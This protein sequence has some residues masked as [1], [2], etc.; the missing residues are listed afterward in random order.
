MW[1]NYFFTL[2]LAGLVV[3]S[4]LR[5]DQRQPGG[6]RRMPNF[7]TIVLGAGGGLN[8]SDLSC[9]LLAPFQDNRFIAFD[10]GTVLAGLQKA[11]TAGSLFDVAVPNESGLSVPG[12]MMKEG[13]KAYLISHSHFDHTNGMVL[14]SPEDGNKTVMGLDNT[15]DDIRDNVFNGRIWS[16][17]GSEGENQIKRY[18]YQRLLPDSSFAI[19]NTAFN[20]R[21]FP[22]SHSRRGSTAFLVEANGQYVLYF[23]DTG[24]DDVEKSAKIKQVWQAVAPLIRE[25]KLRAIFLEI[26]FPDDRPD[27]KLFGHLTP[28]WFM[29]EM[30]QLA[31]LVDPAHPQTALEGQRVVVTHIKPSLNRNENTREIIKKQLE[32]RND[33]TLVLI[34]AEQGQRIVF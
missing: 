17:F 12:W 21:A 15:I 1:R 25:D 29:A 24:P 16:N 8:E 6:E 13:I 26:S 4:S 3:A 9:Y 33:L 7:K 30:H 22:L 23:G 2:A 11:E 20:V 28:K 34:F 10:A 27:D 18:Q 5:A 32:I 14:N 19:P 31:K